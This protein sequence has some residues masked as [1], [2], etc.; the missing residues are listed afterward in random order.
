MKE[1][2]QNGEIIKLDGGA[3]LF[4][5]KIDNIVGEF[6]S[7]NILTIELGTGKYF[8]KIIYPIYDT[9]DY[10]DDHGWIRHV[11]NYHWRDNCWISII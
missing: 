7:I 10:L 11:P 3:E 4:V 6:I 2:P 9:K 5:Y 8:Y 1:L